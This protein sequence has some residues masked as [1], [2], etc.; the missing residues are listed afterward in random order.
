MH[1]ALL[2]VFAC[3]TAAT[4]NALE[5]VTTKA[6]GH[7]P[8][9]TGTKVETYRKIGETELKVWIFNPATKAD[10]PLP[11]SSSAGAGPAGHPRSSNPKADTSR[12]AG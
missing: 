12:A 7:P 9:I 6:A 2:L 1:S 10:K 11:S 3:A 4:L 5:P 8:T